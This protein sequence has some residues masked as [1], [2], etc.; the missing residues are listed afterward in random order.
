MSTITSTAGNVIAVQVNPNDASSGGD[1]ASWQN[2]YDSVRVK[3]CR[4]DFYPLFNSAQVGTT[5]VGLS[6]PPVYCWFDKNSTYSALSV[7]AALEFRT[8]KIYESGKGMFSYYQK[9]PKTI[10]NTTSPAGWQKTVSA[11]SSTG[12]F[13]VTSDG[14]FPASTAVFRYKITWFCDFRD[15]HYA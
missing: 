1:W 5:A 13:G 10:F 12:Y 6:F 15:P 7:G 8:C 14:Y 11:G 2:L 9:M 4:L 3:A